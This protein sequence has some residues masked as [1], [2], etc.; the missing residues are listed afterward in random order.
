MP[1]CGI[2]AFDPKMTGS[3]SCG[4]RRPAKPRNQL[5]EPPMPLSNLLKSAAGTCLFCNQ[6]ASIL[7]REHPGCGRTYQADWQE[8]V[9]L[10][11]GALG[12]TTSS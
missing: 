6:K 9:G 3:V 12:L 5:Y 1:P 8:M 10:P 11:G 2:V 7:S 4:A